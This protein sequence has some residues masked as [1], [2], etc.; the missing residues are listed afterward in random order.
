MIV[1]LPKLEILDDE[2]L[3]DLDREVAEKY[4]EMHNIP[5]PEMPKSVLKQTIVEDHDEGEDSS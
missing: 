4:F 5:K 1:S 2:K 3:R